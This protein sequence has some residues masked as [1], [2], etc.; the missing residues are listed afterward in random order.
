[1]S[2]EICKFFEDNLNNVKCYVRSGGLH[3]EGTIEQ[4]CTLIYKNNQL[5]IY[6]NLKY[7]YTDISKIIKDLTD[8]RKLFP[9]GEVLDY[10]YGDFLVKIKET[11]IKIASIFPYSVTKIEQTYL[12]SEL[13][14]CKIIF[15]NGSI[16]ELISIKKCNPVK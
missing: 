6:I 2:K 8:D 10:L 14:D 3:I 4:E 5:F 7:N 1:M 11:N 15:E 16:I 12:K 13:K 9:Y